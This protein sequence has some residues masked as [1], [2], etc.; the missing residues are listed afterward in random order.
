MRS[1]NGRIIN[2]SCVGVD[3]RDFHLRRHE[4]ARATSI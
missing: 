1:R 2:T 3:G 4:R